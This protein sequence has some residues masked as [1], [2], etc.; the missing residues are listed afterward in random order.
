[1]S[2]KRQ[3][4]NHSHSD[5]AP[6][7]GFALLPRRGRPIFDL[8]RVARRLSRY[9]VAQ[10]EADYVA[11]VISD[12]MFFQLFILMELEEPFSVRL[13]RNPR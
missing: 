13:K 6:G 8:M 10:A 4:L 2:W 3:F 5:C 7:R 11:D 12:S 1:M 9:F